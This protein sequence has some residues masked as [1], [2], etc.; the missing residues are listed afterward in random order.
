MTTPT[1]GFC[2]RFPQDGSANASAQIKASVPTLVGAERL[3]C[4]VS[5]DR[6][7][8]ELRTTTQNVWVGCQPIDSPCIGKM[9]ARQTL[10]REVGDAT[11]TLKYDITA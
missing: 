6:H 9:D 5:C 11:V 3:A 4:K 1:E 7:Y 8:W 2:H 10:N